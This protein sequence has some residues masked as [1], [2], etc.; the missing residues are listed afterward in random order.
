MALIKKLSGP[1]ERWLTDVLAK[2]LTRPLR[3]YEQR[4]PNSVDNLKQSLRVGDIILVEGDQRISQVIRYLTQSSWSH[5]AMYVGDELRR[6]NAAL[7]RE[8]DDQFGADSRFLIVEAD[9]DGVICAPISKYMR[10]NIRICRPRSLRKED[11]DRVLTHLFRQLGRKYNIRHVVELARYFFPVSIVPR[12]YRMAVLHYGAAHKHEVI[13]STLL[14]RAFQSVGYP[15]LP[16]VTIDQIVATPSFWQ[17]VTGQNA[18]GFR[19][20]YRDED[21]ALITPRDFDLS[22]Y[23]DIVKIN[24]LTEPRFDY[25]RIAW[26][27]QVEKTAT[28][29]TPEPQNAPK[30]ESH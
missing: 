12:R 26:A 10:H 3:T 9:N 25:R 5:T 18:N 15:V 30:A 7:A 21:P 4:V 19:A 16:R 2:L 8:L 11:L 24:Y 28:P 20:L 22:P 1:I 29:P 27:H 13:C 17:R 6:F 14:A 23:F